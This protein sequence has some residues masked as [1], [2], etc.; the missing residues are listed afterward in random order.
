MQLETQALGYWLVH[1]VV[2]PVG[3]ESISYLGTFSSSSIQGPVFHPI[4]EC[5]HPLLCLPGPGIA[6]QGTFLKMGF[7][8]EDLEAR[9]ICPPRPLLCPLLSP[10]SDKYS[11]TVPSE[12][13]T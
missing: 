8:F 4:A 6:S 1:I 12:M 11:R 9:D 3:A 7:S 10:T 13:G 5:E 2:P